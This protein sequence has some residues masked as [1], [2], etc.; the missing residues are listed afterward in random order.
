MKLSIIFLVAFGL[1]LTDGYFNNGFTHSTGAPANVCGSVFNT[2]TC[3]SCHSGGSNAVQPG[4]ITS[5]IP[6][7]GY[8]PGTTYTITAMATFTGRS[9]FGFEISPQNNA[10]TKLGTMIIPAAVST[11]MQLIS[12]GRYI[13]HRTG[14]T[15]GTNSKT[16]V[17]DWT[18]PAVGSGNVTFYGAFLCANS[19]NNSSGDFTFKANLP[20]QENLT[21][22][23][24]SI[25]SQSTV[26]IYPNP[27][28]DQFSVYYK[29]DHPGLV[30]IKLYD[31]HGQMIQSLLSETKAPG[32]YLDAFK[33]PFNLN[34]G[35][36]F[37]EIFT[38]TSKTV[39]KM[40]V[41]Q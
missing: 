38:E 33:I 36:Y 13:T 40:L 3:T 7:T 17:F 12:S 24:E 11:Q 30:E 20:V 41:Q 18:A 14:G 4:W 37:L 2:S 6:S 28:T 1:I 27:V 22:G 32:S 5:T 23:I 9:K 25:A 10:G 35:L 16:W 15:A 39:T 8:V 34:P 19:N 21:M 31:L 26:A 29:T